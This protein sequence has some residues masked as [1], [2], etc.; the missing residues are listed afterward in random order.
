MRTR[1]VAVALAGVAV[2]GG[3]QK[4]ATKSNGTVKPAATSSSTATSSPASTATTAKAATTSTTARATTTTTRPAVT[5]T[6]AASVYYP[7]CTAVRAAGKAPLYRGQ[8]GYSSSLDRDGDG[9]AC[10]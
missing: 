2:L 7:N 5:T 8:P 10:E 6:T 9:V 1:L 3:C 4:S